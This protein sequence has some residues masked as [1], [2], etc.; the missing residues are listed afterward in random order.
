MESKRLSTPGGHHPRTTAVRPPLWRVV[1]RS[2]ASRRTD[3]LAD[4]DA[5]CEYVR[6]G[7]FALLEDAIKKGTILV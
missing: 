2:A 6:P 3:R 1:R 4:R 5:V 7:I